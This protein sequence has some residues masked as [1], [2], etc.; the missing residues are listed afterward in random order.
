MSGWM[1][2]AAEDAELEYER[3]KGLDARIDELETENAL[4]RLALEQ[5][6]D[7]RFPQVCA[8][9]ATCQHEGCNASYAAFVIADIAL[10]PTP[11]EPTPEGEK[12][13]G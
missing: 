10:K 9:Y 5:I 4:F 6:R 3:I 8:E 13:N 11:A 1:Q 12:H 7:G 2:R